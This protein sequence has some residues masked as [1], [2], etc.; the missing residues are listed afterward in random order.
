MTAAELAISSAERR[1]I[2]GLILARLGIYRL[3]GQESAVSV[4]D[5]LVT[6]IEQGARY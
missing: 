6:E 3:G 5:A 4:L 2:I 1:R